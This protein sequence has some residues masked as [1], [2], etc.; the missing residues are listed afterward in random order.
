[1]K[2]C[3][4]VTSCDEWEQAR[5]E[6]KKKKR[7]FAWSITYLDEW[8]HFHWSSSFAST[9]FCLIVF[10][11]CLDFRLLRN[12]EIIRCI[13]KS[14][15]SIHHIFVE[16]HL[17]KE[18]STSVFW[19]PESGRPNQYIGFPNILDTSLKW[20]CIFQIWPYLNS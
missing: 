7:T 16:V 17:I 12:F 3:K 13:V 5:K 9:S 20:R 18:N 4:L 14:L 19:A 8:K 15:I 2:H 6:I 11:S 1:M 10:L